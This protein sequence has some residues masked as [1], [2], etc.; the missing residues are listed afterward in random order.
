MYELRIKGVIALLVLLSIAGLSSASVS[1]AR[2]SAVDNP[3]SLRINLLCHFSRQC[4]CAHSSLTTSIYSE[5]GR[6][7]CTFEDEITKLSISELP[8]FI[9]WF[10]IRFIWVG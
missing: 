5:C 9:E 7:T 2:A 4:C 1:T 10:V 3:P 8:R 6:S